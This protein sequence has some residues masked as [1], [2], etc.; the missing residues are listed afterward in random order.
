VPYLGKHFPYMLDFIP[1][2][3]IIASHWA[4]RNFGLLH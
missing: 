1:N 2:F 4:A 3:R